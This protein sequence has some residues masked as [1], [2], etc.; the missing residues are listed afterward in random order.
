MTNEILEADLDPSE[1]VDTQTDQPDPAGEGN[2]PRFEETPRPAEPEGSPPD[3][4]ADLRELDSAPSGPLP[5]VGELEGLRAE[6]NA[7]R[8]ELDRLRRTQADCAEFAELYPEVPVSDLPDAVWEGVEKGIPLAAAYALFQRRKAH[9]KSVAEQ[10]NAENRSRSSG[11]LAD[12]RAGFL[13]PAEVR[14]RSPA[15]VRKNYRNILC[16][17]QKWNR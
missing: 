17:M 3:D 4:P 5:P 6:L 14:E 2:D 15:E 12:A 16:S 10:V 9:E 1:M 8:S 7:L 11:S 13:S